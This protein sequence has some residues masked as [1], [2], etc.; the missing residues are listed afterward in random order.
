MRLK[1]LDGIR[2]L[3]AILLLCGHMA[4][5]DFVSWDITPLPLPECAAYVFFAISGVL[6][7]L[8]ID[9]IHSTHEYYAKKARRILPLYY[10]YILITIIVFF[11]LGRKS[12][13]FNYRLLFHGFLW[14]C[15]AGVLN[16]VVVS[17]YSYG[18]EITVE[19]SRNESNCQNE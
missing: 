10:A 7:G 2:A 6:A 12:E 5:K 19:S 14:L 11:S 3:C 16:N 9:S 18:C 8:R 13:V 17:K 1:G 15:I 4:Q